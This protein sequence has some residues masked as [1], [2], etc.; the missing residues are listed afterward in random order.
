[1]KICFI[2]DEVG[3]ITLDVII[4]IRDYAEKKGINFDC[5]LLAVTI[6]WKSIDMETYDYFE[7]KY[8][9]NNIDI[10]QCDNETKLKEEIERKLQ[11]EIWFMIDVHLK[12]DEEDILEKNSNYKFLSM[13]VM[14]W[15]GSKTYH[16]YSR[17]VE[18]DF[19]IKWSAQFEELYHIDVPNIIEREILQP[20]SFSKECVDKLL[21]VYSI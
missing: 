17:Y 9:E 1:M 2:D 8:N 12:N 20:G 11:K 6:G 15:V 19:V 5:E 14:D 10:I 16:L 3:R 13:K 4:A 7:K 18:T 21:E